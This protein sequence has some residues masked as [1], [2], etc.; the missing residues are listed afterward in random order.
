MTAS[1]DCPQLAAGPYSLQVPCPEC[2]LVASFPVVLAGRLT[3]D[4]DG[5]KL[6]PTLTS[7]AADHKCA[8]ANPTA[9]LF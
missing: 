8:S 5:A 1:S 9:P 4:P 6:R 2:G 7:K 3:V